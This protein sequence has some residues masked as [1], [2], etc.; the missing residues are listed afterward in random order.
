MD[1]FFKTQI[2][3]VADVVFEIRTKPYYVDFIKVYDVS[4]Y[5]QATVWHVFKFNALL[6]SYNKSDSNRYHFIQLITNGLF[7]KPFIATR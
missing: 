6:Y 1:I 2:D 3:I 4:K 7:F 5:I